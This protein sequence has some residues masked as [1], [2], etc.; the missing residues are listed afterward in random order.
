MQL[1]ELSNVWQLEFRSYTAL[2]RVSIHIL[3]IAQ[4]TRTRFQQRNWAFA[5]SRTL[6]VRLLEVG[7]LLVLTWS[8]PLGGVELS[9]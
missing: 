3:H 1:R 9:W 8:R 7:L 5:R 6:K 2:L 4:S